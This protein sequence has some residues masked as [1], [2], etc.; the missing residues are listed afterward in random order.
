MTTDKNICF[1]IKAVVLQFYCKKLV[2]T[3]I[4]CDKIK[5]VYKNIWSVKIFR[6]VI[7]EEVFI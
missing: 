2:H 6:R 4:N 7:N 5:I 3:L 1:V